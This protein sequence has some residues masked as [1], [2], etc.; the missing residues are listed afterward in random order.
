MAGLT[1]KSV[2]SSYFFVAFPIFFS[3]IILII[4]VGFSM[5]L[6]IY[7][8]CSFSGFFFAN[9]TDIDVGSCDFGYCGFFLTMMVRVLMSG[10]CLNECIKRVF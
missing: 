2:T 9:H 5:I 3:L 10:K 7:F 4:D 1:V 6:V 8:L